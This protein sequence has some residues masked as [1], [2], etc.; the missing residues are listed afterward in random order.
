MCLQ[1]FVT[2]ADPLEIRWTNL[3]YGLE[4]KPCTIPERELS[5][6]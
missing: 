4:V 3:H 1:N 6:T 5:A 2:L